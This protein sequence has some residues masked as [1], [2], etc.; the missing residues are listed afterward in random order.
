MEEH[1]RQLVAD[2]AGSKTVGRSAFSPTPEPTEESEEDRLDE[3]EGGQ[4][5]TETEG[6]DSDRWDMRDSEESD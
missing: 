4:S 2:Q 3:G 5:E 1:I 6:A